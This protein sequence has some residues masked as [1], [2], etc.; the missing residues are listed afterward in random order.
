MKKKPLRKNSI[1]KVLAIFAYIISIPVTCL[2]A[3]GTLELY[4]GSYYSKTLDE[5]QKSNMENRLTRDIWRLDEEFT[6][7]QRNGYFDENVSKQ[8]KETLYQELMQN[9]ANNKTN[10]FFAIYDMDDNLLVKSGSGNYQ[11][12]QTYFHT[13]TEYIE[14]E[15]ILSEEEY[16]R[17]CNSPGENY[18]TSATQ[19]IVPRGEPA[20]TLANSQNELIPE[21]ASPTTEEI[22]EIATT[23]IEETEPITE[24][25]TTQDSTEPDT[26]ATEDLNLTETNALLENLFPFAIQ[27]NAENL[28]EVP[29]EIPDD[30]S[31][32]E[33]SIEEMQLICDALDLE[34]NYTEDNFYVIST[35]NNGQ[36]RISF[37]NYLQTLLNQNPDLYIIKQDNSHYV[38]DYHNDPPAII[39]IYEYME[40]YSEEFA[41]NLNNNTASD[42]SNNTDPQYYDIYYDVRISKPEV[43]T[44]HYIVGYVNQ[45]LKAEDDYQTSQKYTA[46]AYQYRYAIPVVTILAGILCL[47]SFIFAVSSAGYHTGAEDAVATN[48]EKIPYDIFT[49]VLGLLGI[50]IT[51]CA[52]GN[53]GSDII[54]AGMLL[55]LWALIILWWA[56]STATRVRTKTIIENT[57]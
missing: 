55:P 30:I 26:S 6:S 52:F 21:T 42:I 57:I 14:S 7:L 18:I 12:S 47:V 2:G 11:M 19:M 24:S 45:A 36:Y 33:Y 40:Y 44:S 35:N 23:T 56:M 31:D 32:S 39:P 34:Y 48:F 4:N 28:I 20:P 13:E 54:L 15:Q 49:V 3:V 51:F 5:I 27:A 8:R 37:K 16:Q 10:F 46:L 41:L 9:Y 38:I 22:S 17:F 29:L 50:A 43:S 53:I 25:I 1:C